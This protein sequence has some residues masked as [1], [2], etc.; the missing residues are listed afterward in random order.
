MTK[1]H[2]FELVWQREV[3]ELQSKASL[4]RHSQSGASLLSFC[5]SDENKVFGATFRTPPA[6][7]TGVAH[8]LE[9]SVLN[10]SKKYPSKEPFVELLKGSLQ[11]FLNAFTYPD[12]TCYPVASANLQDFYNLVDVY[13]DAV[14]HPLLAKSTFEQEGWHVEATGQSAPLLFKGVVYNEMKGVYSSPDSVLGESSQQSIFPHITY[15]LD[16]GGR[17][18]EILRLTYEDFCAFHATFYH[19]SN[20]RFFFWGDDP[21]EKRLEILNAVLREFNSLKL[22]SEVKL[23]EPFKQ[24]RLVE[25]PYAA[26]AQDDEPQ[27]SSRGQAMMTM[28]WLLPETTNVS[29][30]F[31]FQM[32]DH[33]LTGLPGSPLRRALIESGLG[34]DIA[35]GGLENELRQMYYSI[36]LRGV[37]EA[38]IPAVEVLIMDTLAALTED[39]LSAETVEAAINSVE[40]SLRENNTGRFPVGLAIMLRSLTTWLYDDDPLALVAFEKPLQELKARIAAKEPVFEKLIQKYFL[41]NQHRSTVALLPDVKLAEQERLFEEESL[42]ALKDSLDEG[43]LQKLI[44]RA[45]ELKAIQEAPEDPAA[46][47]AIPRLT[48]ADM[49]KEN[50]SIEREELSCHDAP[51]FFH[52]QPTAGIVYADLIFNSAG[53]E[54]ALTPLLPLFGRA[55]LEMG[56]ARRSFVDLGLHIAA[57]TGGIDADAMFL[58][59]WQQRGTLPAF[60]LSGKATSEKLGALVE[61]FEEVLLEGDFD[62]Q[63]RFGQMVLEEKARQEQML[64]PQGHSVVALR[65]QSSLSLA[66]ALSEQTGG[67]AYLDYLRE[68]AQRVENDWPGV[69]ADLLRVRGQ[70]VGRSG[71]LLNLTARAE[72]KGKCEKAFAPLLEKLPAHNVSSGVSPLTLLDGAAFKPQNSK[73]NGEAFLLPAQV[74]YIGQGLNLYEQGYTY[75]GSLQVILKYLRTGY[76]WEEIRVKG[77]AYGAI[78][79]FDRLAGTLCFVSYRDPNVERTLEVYGRIGEHLAKLKLDPMQLESSIVGA[80]GELD[81]YLLPDAKG[82]ASTVRTLCQDTPQMRQR[83]REQ[84][85]ATSLKDFNQFGEWLQSVKQ[86]HVC[87]LG[88]NEV[89]KFARQKG[90]PSRKA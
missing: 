55:M 57:K 20:T 24:P 77:G 69:L 9:H 49:P 51:L 82:F 7:S 73:D 59:T 32:L 50:K 88:G 58:T 4:W 14:F 13:L 16:S 38:D 1:L 30:N 84:I 89:E 72:D 5:N 75:H 86:R 31:A 25:V 90:L 21:E 18:Q 22:D 64:V 62:D 36:G 67:I 35:G 28:N 63:Q 52:P 74:N 3:D 85:L 23:Q 66:G 11:T 39:G 76:L 71:L 79:S 78:S 48:V 45:K 68:L 83:M 6:N 34:E 42:A 29:E 61:I 2:G 46:L 54:P 12:K 56:T 19:P 27:A 37:K 53:L 70:I 17:P 80:V 44:E 81:A 43:G 40:F 41:H 47:R 60:V 10:G 33:I 15:G 87:L 26:D 8:I 65:L